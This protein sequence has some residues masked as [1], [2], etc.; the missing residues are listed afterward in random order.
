MA[1]EA[2]LLCTARALQIVEIVRA[3][4]ARKQMF[5]HILIEVLLVLAL[6]YTRIRESASSI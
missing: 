1:A 3:R 4:S 2:G 5:S 6:F